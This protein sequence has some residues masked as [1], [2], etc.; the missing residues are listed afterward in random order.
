[1]IGAD[2]ER[3]VCACD[4]RTTSIQDPEAVVYYSSMSCI[5]WAWI[6]HEGI[7]HGNL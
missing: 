7:L 6:A 4:T 5:I 1:M 2:L 3:I